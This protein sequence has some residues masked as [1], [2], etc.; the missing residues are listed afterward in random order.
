[1]TVQIDTTAENNGIRLVVQG[2]HPSSPSAGHV[3]LYYVTGTAFPGMFV[4]D[5]GGRK[6]GPF[7]TGSSGGSAGTFTDYSAT[8]SVS[9]WSA[10]PTV[11]IWV[12]KIDRMVMVMF[13]ISGTSNS[14]GA[15]FTVPNVLSNSFTNDCMFPVVQVVDNGIGST[16]PGRAAM[17]H[18]STTVTLGKDAAGNNFTNS[19]TKVVRGSFTY[20][21][22]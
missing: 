13:F 18:N 2:N 12:Y 10:T 19:G 7:I 21:T 11:A 8:S 9:G 20:F 5:S 3:L 1:M 14:T 22:D 16:T 17:T 15:S 4:E 6:Y